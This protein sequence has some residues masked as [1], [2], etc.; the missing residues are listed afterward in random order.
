MLQAV[1]QEKVSSGQATSVQQQHQQQGHSS[2]VHA[3][4]AAQPDNMEVDGQQVQLQSEQEAL[5]AIQQ[6]SA[7]AVAAIIQQHHR[8]VEQLQNTTSAVANGSVG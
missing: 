6:Q 1:L 2:E 5:S 4:G 8:F 7:Q 3:G